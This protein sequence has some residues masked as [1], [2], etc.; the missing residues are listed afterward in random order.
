[1][2]AIFG[3]V[4]FFDVLRRLLQPQLSHPLLDERVRVAPRLPPALLAVDAPHHA[5]VVHHLFSRYVDPDKL[6]PR[7]TLCEL[8]W[9]GSQGFPG[10]DQGPQNVFIFTV[11][12]QKLKETEIVIIKYDLKGRYWM[13]P[14]R[15]L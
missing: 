5:V 3:M 15:K 13:G 7:E 4:N 9:P 6:C 11:K 1:M 10:A 12:F 8:V 14:T 2:G